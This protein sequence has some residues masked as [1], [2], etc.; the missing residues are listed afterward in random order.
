MEKELLKDI[1]EILTRGVEEIIGKD[2]LQKK[3]FSGEKLRIKFG[4]DPTGPKIHIGRAISLWKL[5]DF[6]DLGHKIVFIVGD[7]TAQIGDASDKTAARKPLLIE[8]I[9]E[10][11]KG[12]IAQTGKILNMKK[13]EIRYNSEWLDKL[14]ARDLIKL[15]MFFT[16]QQLIQRRNFK[17]RWDQGKEIGLHELDYPLLQGYD[18]VSVKADLE[19]GGTDQ[20]FNFL[21]GRKIQEAFGQKPQDIITLKMLNGLDGRKMS[22]SWGNTI[23]ITDDPQEMYGKTM[24]LRDEL[25]PD[26]FELCARLPIEE[27]EKIKKEIKD[28]KIN[29]RD[30]KARLAKRIVSLYHGE[31][32]GENAEKEFN[33]IFREKELP[34][35]I[36]TV[37]ISQKTL[38]LADL[39]VKANMA[40]SK[41]EAKRLIEQKGVTINEEIQN[42]AK[43]EILIKKGTVIKVGK[44]NFVK[45]I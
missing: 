39:L 16:A 6:Q 31:K 8:E 5:K 28:K 17:E 23:S 38:N 45:L 13:V 32:E 26:Y 34:S 11:M 21:A 24:S 1:K 12:Y 27:V 35:E 33:R 43:K 22:T 37:K 42:D 10:N 4:I 14:S 29:P 30:A 40:H 18:S 36:M 3:L 9:K 44:R 7:F 2:N 15:S 19:I 25:M 41:A 20:L